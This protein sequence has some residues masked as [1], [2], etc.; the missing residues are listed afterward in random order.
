MG[1]DVPSFLSSVFD[2]EKGVGHF[3]ANGGYKT[4]SNIFHGSVA[5]VLGWVRPVLN[6]AVYN[7]DKAEKRA[8]GKRGFVGVAVYVFFLIHFVIKCLQD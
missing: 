5:S 6:T 4:A 7:G 3:G 1:Q 8:R 2:V